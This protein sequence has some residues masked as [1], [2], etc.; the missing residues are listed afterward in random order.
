MLTVKG[1]KTE[2]GYKN[3]YDTIEIKV[4]KGGKGYSMGRWKENKKSTSFTIFVIQTKHETVSY[5]WNVSVS[6]WNQI[7]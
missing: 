5:Y 3:L 7:V 1:V 4:E 2:S 6:D